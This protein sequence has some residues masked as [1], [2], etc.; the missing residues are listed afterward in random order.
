MHPHPIFILG[1]PIVLLDPYYLLGAGTSLMDD[2]EYLRA[3]GVEKISRIEL[4]A[5]VDPGTVGVQR[6]DGCAEAV[7]GFNPKRAFRRLK[8]GESR[9]GQF[10]VDGGSVLLFDIGFLSEA[11]QAW[12][13]FPQTRVSFDVG[14]ARLFEKR[15]GNWVPGPPVARVTGHREQGEFVGDGEYVFLPEMLRPVRGFGK[16]QWRRRLAGE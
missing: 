10:S 3:S 5:G 1:G 13:E 9:E 11:V 14:A 12:L 16:R 2:E 4:L 15:T 7:Y 8:S 6:C